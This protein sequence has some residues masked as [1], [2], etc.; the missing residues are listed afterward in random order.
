VR[1]LA[2]LMVLLWHY[3]ASAGIPVGRVAGVPLAMCWSG[4]DLFFVLSGFLIGGILIDER[5]SSNYFR[6]F[7]GR[8]AA[9]ILPLYFSWL[10]LFVV[11]RPLAPLANGG[12]QWLFGHPL[13]LASYA[14]FTQNFA[15]WRAET[16][17]PHWLAMS[18]SLAIEEQF[19][20]VLPLLVFLIPPRRLP[21]V[22]A[23]LAAAAPVSRYVLLRNGG[24]IGILTMPFCRAD[25]L[26]FGVLA[27]WAVRERRPLLMRVRRWLVPLLIAVSIGIG[28]M[29]LAHQGY[30]SWQMNLYGLTLLAVAYTLVILIVILMPAGWLAGLC[31]LR[32][33]RA[34]GVV[35]YAT[36]VF[37]QGVSGLVFALFRGDEPR[38]HQRSDLALSLLAL[39]CTFA[40]AT[41][42]WFALERPL[43]RSA[44][45]LRYRSTADEV[46]LLADSANHVLD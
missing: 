14:T 3:V 45:Q 43:L 32:W 40:L 39:F 41:V 30:G 25:A 23:L 6:V 33:L 37:H 28:S 4:V 35:S 22:V 8:R 24:T 9:R 34:A 21:H 19:Y 17:G 12:M 2:I 26:L 13:P 27:A 7:Y 15:M 11:V 46:D 42:S 36:Y 20:L 1:G 38:F 31:R 18:W 5:S 44:S 29:L 10:L 16:F